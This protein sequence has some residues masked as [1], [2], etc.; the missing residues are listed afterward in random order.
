MD[1]PIVTGTFFPVS[2]ISG[3]MWCVKPCGVADETRADPTRCDMQPHNPDDSD[4]DLREL[5]IQNADR[6]P[7]EEE[8]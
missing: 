1:Q 5:F 8:T 3:V 6:L 7:N 4:C 2:P